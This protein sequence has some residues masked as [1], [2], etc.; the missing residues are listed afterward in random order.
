[1]MRDPATMLVGILLPMMLLLLFGYGLSL[2]VRNVPM[3]IVLEEPSPE[4]SQVAAGFQLSPYFNAQLFTSMPQAT[5][6]MLDRKV[7]GIVRIRADFTRRLHVGATP[8]VQVLV[9]GTDAN[10][11]RT[12]ESY[13]QGAI[14][15]GR[16]GRQTGLP[17]RAGPVSCRIVF[18]STKPTR[19][20]L[21]RSRPDRAGDDPDRRLPDRAGHGARMGTGNVRGDLRHAGACQ[22]DPARQDRSLFRPGHD[23]LHVSCHHGARPVR[24]A[25]ARLAPRADG[26]SMLYLLVSVGFG[27]FISSVTKSQFVA[28][29]SRWSSPSCRPCCSPASCSTSAP[30]RWRCR[31]SPTS[32][33]PATSSALV[34]TIFLAGD[35]W[36][37]HP[38]QC[39]RVLALMAFVLLVAAQ[40]R[41][42]RNSPESRP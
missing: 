38:A 15:H 31:S 19:A 12:I 36:A 7:D 3:A 14:A 30:C 29:R 10:R 9:N 37:R 28:R 16:R 1:M 42:A 21:S 2:D 11:A 41:H 27:L 25:A 17:R 39:G 18:G 26:G 8:E 23:R 20:A 6:L 32:C 34:Q 13:A 22:R 5:E 40:R 33:R 24:R 4:A 35:I